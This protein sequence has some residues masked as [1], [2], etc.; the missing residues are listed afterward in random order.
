MKGLATAVLGTLIGLMLGAIWF[1]PARWVAQ[2]VASLTQQHVQLVNV[3]GTVWRGQADLMLTAGTA[4]GQAAALP[5]GLSWHWQPVWAGW[6]PG[7]QL[8]LLAPC[9]TPQ[10]LQWQWL[11]GQHHGAPL[12]MHAAELQLPLALVQGLGAPWNTLQP[13]GQLRVMLPAMRW[14]YGQTMPVIDGPV[15]FTLLNFGSRLST[16]QPLGSYQLLLSANAGTEPQ[17]TLS[18][19][20]GKLQLSGQ[21]SWT[22]RGLRF[23]GLA[24]TDAQSIDALSN[25]L[26]LL[27]RRDGLRSHL[28]FG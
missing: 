27:G 1:A 25:L 8:R 3:H 11:P 13:Q 7:L 6:L 18:T 28:R 15:Q 17:L 4:P 9:C 22:A 20:H 24:E 16:L 23:Q 10:P 21:G 12:E 2:A 14:S 26:N 19:L 5:S